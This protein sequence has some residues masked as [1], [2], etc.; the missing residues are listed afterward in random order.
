M[1]LERKVQVRRLLTHILEDLPPAHPVVIAG[2][3]NEW[4]R[5]LVQGALHE[6]RFHLARLDHHPVRGEATWPSQ[7]PLVCLDRV[8]YRDPVR[9]HHVQCVLDAATRTASDHLPV[10][11]QLEVPGPAAFVRQGRPGPDGPA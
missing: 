1:H 10:M 2:D 5:R 11:V 3:W 7:R 4:G 6:A 8:L 9:V